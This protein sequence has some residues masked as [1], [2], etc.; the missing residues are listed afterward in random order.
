MGD[1]DGGRY[2]ELK[3][4]AE[5][6]MEQ[7]R[8]REREQGRER[9]LSLELQAAL[10][11]A[12]VSPCTPH[13]QASAGKL[14]VQNEPTDQECTSHSLRNSARE[15]KLENGVSLGPVGACMSLMIP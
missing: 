5:R 8:E 13:L 15:E 11:V 2:A 9:L 14:K 12:T 7:E 10:Q 6:E 3:D 4:K 1:C